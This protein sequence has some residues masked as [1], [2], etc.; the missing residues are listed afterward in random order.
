MN[1]ASTTTVACFG[2][3]LWMLTIFI[4]S[5]TDIMAHTLLSRINK[6]IIQYT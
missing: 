1:K 5:M 6:Q 3:L 2:F 4:F